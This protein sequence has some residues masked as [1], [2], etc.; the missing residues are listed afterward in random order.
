[1]TNKH[2]EY[3]NSFGTERKRELY[4][5]LGTIC[6]KLNLD[7]PYEEGLSLTEYLEKHKLWYVLYL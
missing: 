4:K 1:M 7:L 2:L 6:A 3:L 5:T